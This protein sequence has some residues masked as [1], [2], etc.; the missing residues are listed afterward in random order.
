MKLHSILLILC[1]TIS[2]G[3]LGAAYFAAGYWQ[4]LFVFPLFAMLWF[5]VKKISLF[6][7]AALYLM[8]YVLL[9]ATGIIIDLSLLLMLIAGTT[10]LASW[11]LMQFTPQLTK[12]G[13]PQMNDLLEAYHLKALGLVILSGLILT[14]FGTALSLE[15]PFSITILLVIIVFGGLLFGLGNMNRMNT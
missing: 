12:D 9:A 1:L 8:G 11:E 10:T 3:S 4:I 6:W 14:L 2:T 5:W 13:R 15:I 7:S